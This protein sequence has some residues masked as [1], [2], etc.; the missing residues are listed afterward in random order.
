MPLLTFKYRHKV[1]LWEQQ[2]SEEVL[3]KYT[4]L[5]LGN[6]LS[7]LV[8]VACRFDSSSCFYGCQFPNEEILL[9]SCRML[10]HLD[11]S[12]CDF[13]G[14]YM[15]ILLPR[16]WRDPL[17]PIEQ[18][19]SWVRPYVCRYI[20]YRYIC[21]CELER[22]LGFF[23]I[24]LLWIW[25]ILSSVITILGGNWLNC[26]CS[27]EIAIQLCSCALVDLNLYKTFLN[28]MINLIQR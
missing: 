12:L 20:H 9:N 21:M 6:W 22:G 15:T 8:V 10:H 14:E 16:G 4:A 3:S 24:A 27:M 28:M 2:A 25:N 7:S 23:I 11:I 5:F 1:M 13:L 17:D 19:N 18:K 26:V